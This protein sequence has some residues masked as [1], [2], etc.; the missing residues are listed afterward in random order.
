MEIRSGLGLRKAYV[1]VP[2]CEIFDRSDF[3]GFY[4]INGVKIFFIYIFWGS[5]RA[6]KFLMRML[7]LIL[8]K[9]F[10]LVWPT[11]KNFGLAFETICS[12]KRF[13]FLGTLKLLKIFVNLSLCSEIANT[14][15]NDA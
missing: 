3:H 7:S 8:R 12:V 2:K 4:T 15:L 1:K 9:K 14:N 11:K 10:F 5:F 13:A 6:A